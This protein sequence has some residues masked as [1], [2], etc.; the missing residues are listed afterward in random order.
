M[1]IYLA[2]MVANLR[3]KNSG[4]NAS[5][6]KNDFETLKAYILT[7]ASTPYPTKRVETEGLIEDLIERMPCKDINHQSTSDARTTQNI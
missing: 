2:N 5:D 6:T 1:F 4:V 3:G 7:T